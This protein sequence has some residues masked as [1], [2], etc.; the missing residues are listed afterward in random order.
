M[1]DIGHA[2]RGSVDQL[3]PVRH[4]DDAARCI[5]AVVGFEELL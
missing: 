4:T 5:V 3:A 2:E 1:L